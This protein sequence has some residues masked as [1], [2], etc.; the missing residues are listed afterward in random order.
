MNGSKRRKRL[1]QHFLINAQVIDDMIGF[2]NPKEDD[3]IV[4]IGPGHGAL[5][6]RLIHRVKKFCAIEFDAELASKLQNSMNSQTASVMF[7]NALEFDY[8]SVQTD[9]AKLRVVGNLPYSISTQLIINLL[10]YAAWIQDMCFMV[11]KEV[12]DRLVAKVGSQSYGR[13]TVNVSR[14]F[15]VDTVFDVSPES[16][17]PPPKVQS[18]VIFLRPNSTVQADAATV[19]AFTQLVRLAFGNRRKTLKN[20]LAGFA[21]DEAFKISG[22]DETLRAQNLSVDHFL[23]LA[24]NTLVHGTQTLEQKQ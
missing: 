11:Q 21:S 12:A 2:I 14:V 5:T 13:L 24:R 19:Q 16:F 3:T 20:S 4:E 1:G 7:G 22:I 23:R 15:D 10:D 6:N 17:L 9:E 18:T 8:S